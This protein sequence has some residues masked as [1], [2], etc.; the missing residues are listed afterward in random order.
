MNL[1]SDSECTCDVGIFATCE[2]CRASELGQAMNR[3]QRYN[4]TPENK[5]PTVHIV[6]LMLHYQNLAKEK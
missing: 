5:R 4:N 6:D 1:E 3:T 2:S